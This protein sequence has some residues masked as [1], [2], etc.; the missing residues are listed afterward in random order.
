MGFP[1]RAH[2]TS[3]RMLLQFRS[4]PYQTSILPECTPQVQQG[5]NAAERLNTSMPATRAITA[6][7]TLQLRLR[8]ETGTQITHLCAQYAATS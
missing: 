8:A 1:N 6:F 5:V 2:G 7:A 4:G 3:A